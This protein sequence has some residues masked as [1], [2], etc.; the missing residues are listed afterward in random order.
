MLGFNGPHQQLSE[1]SRRLLDG[2]NMFIRQTGQQQVILPSS[3]RVKPSRRMKCSKGN[4]TSIPL[5]GLR[6]MSHQSGSY[7]LHHLW[8]SW[9][10]GPIYIC[11]RSTPSRLRGTICQVI[12][13]RSTSL[14]RTCV[15][16]DEVPQGEDVILLDPWGV[17]D[18]CPTST[19]SHTHVSQ[20]KLFSV[21]RHDPIYIC[22]KVRKS[23]SWPL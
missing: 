1:R 21:V 7:T 15:S 4:P 19:P 16:K 10:S 17:I 13:L 11:F 6:H 2:R 9:T 12:C 20:N 3:A 5:C 23:Y 8:W 22:L 18:M 14:H